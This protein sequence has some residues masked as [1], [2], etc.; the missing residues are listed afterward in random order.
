MYLE[1]ANIVEKQ[2]QLLVQSSR[3]VASAILDH[4]GSCME[5]PKSS[6]ALKPLLAYTD[7]AFPQAQTSV[8][9]EGATG[10][11]ISLPTQSPTIVKHPDWLPETGF[12]GDRKSVV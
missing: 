2:I 1:R 7:E 6:G 3:S 9:V 10:L 12:S 11:K 8:A 4:A 5:Q